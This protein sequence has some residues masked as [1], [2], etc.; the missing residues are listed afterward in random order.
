MTVEFCSSND[1]NPDLPDFDSSLLSIPTEEVTI[2]ILVKHPRSGETRQPV[3]RYV[4]FGI[5]QCQGHS[6]QSI[7]MMVLVSSKHLSKPVLAFRLANVE[8]I[9]GHCW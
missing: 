9:V 8:A 2:N 6:Q 3:E 5:C 4:K 1:T 7:I